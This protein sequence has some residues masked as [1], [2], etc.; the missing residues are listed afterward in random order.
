MRSRP[1]RKRPA[2]F[3]P[4]LLLSCTSNIPAVILVCASTN[5]S[6]ACTPQTA[7]DVFDTAYLNDPHLAPGALFVVIRAVAGGHH[8]TQEV[9][10][11]EPRFPKPVDQGIFASWQRDG[12]RRVVDAVDG[13]VAIQDPVDLVPALAEAAHVKEQLGPRETGRLIVAASG[14]ELGDVIP[15]GHY[16]TADQFIEAERKRKVVPDLG[17]FQQ[18]IY[19]GFDRSSTSTELADQRDL[20]W[21]E[22][23]LRWGG[24]APRILP[25]CADL[26]QTGSTP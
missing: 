19:C 13:Q 21:Y 18:I 9:H 23:T 25:S 22:A 26:P 2:L 20:L 4:M 24:P 3:L 12:R 11:V 17:M 6:E 10:V 8:P 5:T 7:G 1:W 14:L 15:A 16:P